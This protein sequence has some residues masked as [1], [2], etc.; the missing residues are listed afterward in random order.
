MRFHIE[1]GLFRGSRL[2]GIPVT[3]E[4]FGQDIAV[5]FDQIPIP[6]HLRRPGVSLAVRS[7]HRRS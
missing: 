7:A 1:S 4:C 3:V 6:K 5:H 2:N